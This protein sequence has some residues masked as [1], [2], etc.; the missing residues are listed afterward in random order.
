MPWRSPEET[1]MVTAADKTL[2]QE[3]FAKIAPIADDAAALFY[4][5]LFEV[6]PSLQAMF[7]GP[8]PEQRRKLMQMLTAA[9]KGLDHIDRLVPVLQDLGRR[10][11]AYG[12]ST[13]HYDTVAK[14]L[15]WTLEKGL[16]PAFTPETRRAWTTVYSL[17]AATMQ[18]A[19][20]ESLSAA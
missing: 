1:A 4:R 2:V 3:S 15:L 10:H 13:A 6:D 17:I 16:G 11:A 8:M 18:E 20:R 5:R 9:V 7:R 12:V 14:A 19:A